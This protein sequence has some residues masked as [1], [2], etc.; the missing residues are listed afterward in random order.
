MPK[1]SLLG[2]ILV[3]AISLVAQAQDGRLHLIEDGQPAATIVVPENPG[4]WTQE[5]AAWLQE[6]A[7]KATGAKLRVVTE[8]IAPEGTLISIGHTKMAAA[9][10][11]DAHGLKFDGCKLLVKGSVLYLIGRDDPKLD[12]YFAPGD[13][14]PVQLTDWVGARGTCR[15][16]I[17]FLEDFLRRPVVPSRPAGRACTEGDRNP[18]SRGPEPDLPAGIR[19]QQQPLTL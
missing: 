17:K 1:Q 11:I 6:Y 16:V 3:S 4:R 12:T 2:L 15:A 19:V 5:A 10:G 13:G 9:A 8:D 18:G 7:Q 14:S